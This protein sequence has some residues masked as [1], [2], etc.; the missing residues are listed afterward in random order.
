MLERDIDDV[1]IH[2]VIL[3]L[4]FLAMKWSVVYES[5]SFVTMPL[6]CKQ[7]IVLIL[8]EKLLQVYPF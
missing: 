3:K 2:L 7:E 1:C 4:R 8:S 6:N 5:A